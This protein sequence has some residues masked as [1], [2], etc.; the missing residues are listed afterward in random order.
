M[1]KALQMRSMSQAHLHLLVGGWN[2]PKDCIEVISKEI[3]Q[4]NLDLGPEA[5]LLTHSI[6]DQGD[7][8]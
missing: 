3:V 1:I 5:P 8:R 7:C 2:G 6:Q 4:E